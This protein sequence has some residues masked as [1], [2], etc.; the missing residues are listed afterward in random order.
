MAYTEQNIG[1][2]VLPAKRRIIP[3]CI[4]FLFWYSRFSTYCTIPYITHAFD[5]QPSVISFHSNAAVDAVQYEMH[6]FLQQ[7]FSGS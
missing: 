5:D 4:H 7:Y 3:I 2:A 6:C 1:A